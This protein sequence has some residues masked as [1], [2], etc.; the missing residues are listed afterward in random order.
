MLFRSII[1]PEHVKPSTIKKGIESHYNESKEL[2]YINGEAKIMEY[3]PQEIND[4]SI[5]DVI[6]QWERTNLA[7]KFDKGTLYGIKE[8]VV[9]KKIDVAGGYFEDPETEE[10]DRQGVPSSFHEGNYT[11]GIFAENPEYQTAKKLFESGA[12]DNP[13]GE[14][15]WTILKDGEV[16]RFQLHGMR[17]ENNG[18][19]PTGTNGCIRLT[20][21]DISQSE[22][23]FAEGANLYFTDV[24]YIID[25]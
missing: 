4:N 14:G 6:I 12:S 10:Y 5:T 19:A 24:P 18:N 16:T 15:L 17:P 23:W 13:Y 3:S 22:N 21:N 1:A 25:F 2:I 11:L 7:P 9:V 8:G 20:N